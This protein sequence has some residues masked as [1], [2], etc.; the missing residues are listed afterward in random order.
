MLEIFFHRITNVGDFLSSYDSLVP[1]ENH[2]NTNTTHR[3]Y[4]ADSSIPLT[5]ILDQ[6]II[7]AY[8][9]LPQQDSKEEKED[10][11]DDKS[12]P[13]EG[14]SWNSTYYS[15]YNKPKF[16]N[17]VGGNNL[18]QVL[19]G[20]ASTYSSYGQPDFFGQ[21]LVI[22]Y[23]HGTTRSQLQKIVLDE[24]KHFFQQDSRDLPLPENTELLIL[25]DEG[26]QC[27]DQFQVDDESADN[28]FGLA[29][30]FPDR[31]SCP[32]EKDLFEKDCEMH[33]SCASNKNKKSRPEL[34]LEK[35]LEATFEK[36]RLGKQDTWFCPDCRNHVRAY[37]HRE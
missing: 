29:I 8:E 28:I 17:D 19:F 27:G 3:Y 7:I 24:I 33:E 36:E 34:T 18:L 14:N 26:C 10:D 32:I 23:P 20:V 6:D 25:K 4:T 31:A 11:E 5:N 2:S 15:S 16:P 9:T 22:S 35:C 13:N 12:S 21:P 1:R 30:V 37:V